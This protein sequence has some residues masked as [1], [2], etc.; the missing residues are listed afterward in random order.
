MNLYTLLVE[1]EIKKSNRLLESI[2]RD[3][4]PEQKIVVEGIYN[5][6]LPLIEAS[7]TA[8]QIRQV[9]G[10]VEK[11][12]IAS[13]Q[14]RTLAGKGIDTA[15]K[16]NEIINNVGK[17]LQ[18]TT[19]VKAFDQKFDDLKRQINT[20]F[21]DSKILD[22]VSNL[23][24]WVKE[25]PGKSAAVIGILTAIAALAGGPVGGAIAGQVLRGSA[26]LLKGEKLSTAVGKGLKT[27]AVGWL[28]GMSMDAVGDMISDVYQQFNPI[29]ISGSSSYS[30]VNVGNGLPSTFQDAAIY[31]DKAQL[32]QFRTMWADAVKQWQNGDYAAAQQAFDR[33]REFAEKVSVETMNKIAIE[34]DPAEKIR[35]LNQALDGFSAAAQGAAS[36][37]TSYDRQGKPVKQESYYRQTRPLSEGQVYMMFE[38]V[39]V[40]AGIMDK[41]KAGAGKVA[42]AVGKGAAWAGKQATEQITSAKL[43][44]AWKLEG[45]P[46]DS[47]DLAKFLQ[48]QGVDPEVVKSVFTELKLPVDGA[49][50]AD[51][52]ASGSI[53]TQVKNSINKMDKK[54][55]QR[56]AAYLQKQLGTA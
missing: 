11:Q 29:P 25:N 9:F 2:S 7:L 20:K 53:Y 49:A 35:A 22:G 40:E 12:S 27:A 39:I 23:G 10:A 6:M 36:G 42:G 1:E 28:A 15:K 19:P 50:A 3:L 4:L 41:I 54:G 31:G 56:L 14:S 18:N 45:S 26:E 33:A 55:K 52:A 43:L 24:I 37:A 47:A 17:W 38:R 13:G 46:T 34:G 51:P 44:A 21:P 5:E 48:D 32:G 16:A 30:V 8:D